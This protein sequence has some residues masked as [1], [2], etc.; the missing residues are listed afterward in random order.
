MSL[1]MGSVMSLFLLGSGHANSPLGVARAGPAGHTPPKGLF[2]ASLVH[3]YD[4][5]NP[6][7][8]V[9]YKLCYRAGRLSLTCRTLADMDKTLH[10]VCDNPECWYVGR[11][12]RVRLPHVGLGIWAKPQLVCD[13]NWDLRV[14]TEPAPEP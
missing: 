4:T 12:R 11:V 14:T 9:E 1:S 5:V 6:P 10:V 2:R 3:R 7:L 8:K 13:C